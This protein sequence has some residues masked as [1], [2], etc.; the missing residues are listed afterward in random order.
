MIVPHAVAV[1][2]ASLTW[3]GFAIA[4]RSYF[5]GARRAVRAKSWLTWSALACTAVQIA[6]VVR[7]KPP[8]AAWGWAGVACFL[9][10]NLVFWW[11]LAV[12]GKVRPAFAFIEGA[13][14]SF[15]RV[16]PYRLIRHPIYTAY[17][18][19]WAAGA[20]LTGK[21]WL[22]AAVGWMGL[23]FYR[24]ARQEERAFA[25]SEFAPAYAEYRKQTGMFLPKV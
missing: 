15:T 14:A 25:A 22:L 1:L 21:L 5:R 9:L 4:M 24:A 11:S 6:A 7:W 12:H 17:L 18:L 8:A 19:A 20:V 23:F 3:S 16:G 10:A 2:A 13:P